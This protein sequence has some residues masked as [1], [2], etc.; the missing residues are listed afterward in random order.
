MSNEVTIAKL[1]AVA[2]SLIQ[3]YERAG[4]RVVVVRPYG[5]DD[6]SVFFPLGDIPFCAEL[7]YKGADA[8]VAHAGNPKVR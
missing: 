2:R 6:V 7:L 8:V 5:A 1:D 3:A 4:V